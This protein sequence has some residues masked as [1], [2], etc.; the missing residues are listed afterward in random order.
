MPLPD[1]FDASSKAGM[2]VPGTKPE[3]S[4]TFGGASGVPEHSKLVCFSGKCH[5]AALLTCLRDFA[6]VGCKKIMTIG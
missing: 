4:G 5:P 2:S 3:P 6:L 1:R